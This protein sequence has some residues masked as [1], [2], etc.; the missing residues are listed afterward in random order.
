MRRRDRQHRARVRAERRAAVESEP[1]DPQQ[2]GAD[3]GERQIVGREIVRA[4]ALTAAEHE[5]RDQAG[6]AGTQMHHRAAGE[7]EQSGGAEEAAAPDPMRERHVHDDEPARGKQQ[8]G[9]EAH[10]VGDGS[11]D[12]RHGDDRERHLVKRKQRFRDGLGRRV[13]A[14]HRHAQRGRRARACRSTGRRRQTPASSRRRSTARRSAPQ[15][16]G[17]APW[18]QAR[19]SCAPCR[20]RTAPVP[21]SSSSARARSQRSSRPCRQ[22]R[23]WRLARLA[24]RRPVLPDAMQT[25]A[26]PSAARHENAVMSSPPS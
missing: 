10:A 11:C 22:R 6:D 9:G 19:S 4:V 2:A 26:A 13:D 17:F 12:Q 8:V 3:D 20:H 24:A 21:G 5:G 25:V 14:V 15:R 1:A 23:S 16:R 7:I 18:S